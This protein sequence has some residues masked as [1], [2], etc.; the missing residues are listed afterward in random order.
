MNWIILLV[1]DRIYQTPFLLSIYK[2]FKY[3]T[4]LTTQTTEI[5][6]L[7]NSIIVTSTQLAMEGT[8]E[9]ERLTEIEDAIRVPRDIIVRIDTSVRYSK[10]LVRERQDL[11]Q[12]SCSVQD[13]LKRIMIKK[14]F[15]STNRKSPAARVLEYSL[16]RIYESNQLLNDIERQVNTKYD[17]TNKEHE[18]KLLQLWRCLMPDTEL[19]SRVSK[20]WT[21]I[22]FQ[23]N[24]P[25][26]D[27]RGMGVQGL[28][29]LL[30]FA[31]RH[32]RHALSVLQQASHPVYW[33]PYAI[34]GIN[35][36]K[37]AYQLLESKRLQ[38]YLFQYAATVDSFQ[39][40]YAY[41]FYRFNHFWMTHV[42]RLTVMEFEAKFSEFQQ[43]IEKDLRKNDVVKPLSI[44]VQDPINLD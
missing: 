44:L 22:G 8:E 26:T 11:T 3:L 37:F 29:D 27:F 42:P 17:T 33:Y 21:D 7:C 16:E 31:K 40:F 4:R 30:Y 9:K 32:P 6:R 36:T 15:S 38:P 35:I 24:D 2:A 1:L 25:A 39:E 10:E 13:V 20:Q 14:Q 23:G 5:Y 18:E 12:P 34:V 43:L 28:D 41:L 19:E